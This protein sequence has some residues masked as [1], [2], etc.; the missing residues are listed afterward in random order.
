MADQF[1]GL[2]TCESHAQNRSHVRF[3]ARVSFCSRK[4]LISLCCVA[5]CCIVLRCVALHCATFCCVAL[6]CVVKPRTHFCSLPCV[7]TC[8]ALH[9]T[10]VVL[11]CILLYSIFYQLNHFLQYTDW[12][13]RQSFRRPEC[14][15]RSS[16]ERKLGN[17]ARII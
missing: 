17:Y 12:Y 13:P 3:T 4:G 2:D 9:Y 6:C 11:F 1:S 16:R 15:R 5:S 7:L 8:V 10:D 14:G